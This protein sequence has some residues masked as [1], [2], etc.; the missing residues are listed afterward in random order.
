MH[1]K[2][3]A[4]RIGL[5]AMIILIF[6]GVGEAKLGLS[7]SFR[8]NERMEPYAGGFGSNGEYQSGLVWDKVEWCEPLAFSLMPFIV[9]FLLSL[10]TYKMRDEVFRAWWRFARWWAPVIIIA[11][12]LLENAGG[13]GGIGISGAVSTAFDILILGVLYAVLVIVS[14]FQIARAYF[15]KRW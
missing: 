7:C 6:L 14:L 2:K 13:G 12:L 3:I 4:L 9:I 8:I 5:G 1:T 11:T 10:I 15:G